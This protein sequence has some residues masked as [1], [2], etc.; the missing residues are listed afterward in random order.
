MKS[1]NTNGTKVVSYEKLK[2]EFDEAM[3]EKA[4]LES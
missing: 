4:H 3:G 1:L 2:I